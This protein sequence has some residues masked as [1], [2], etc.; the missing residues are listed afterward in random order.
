MEKQTFER[1]I[2]KWPEWHN[3]IEQSRKLL[4]YDPAW[5]R[6]T[7][8]A[9]IEEHLKA[10][11]DKGEAELKRLEL[12]PSLQIYWEDC[13]YIDYKRPDGS[14]DYDRITRYF[15]NR[16][17]LPEMPCNYGIVWHE[18]E[19]I[20][21]PWL[22]VE[23]KLH[24]RFATKELLDYAT[25]YAYESVESYL[26]SENIQPHSICEWLKGGRPPSDD[27]RALEC[28]HLKDD[29]GWT[30]CEIGSH[31]DDLTPFY[32]PLW[33]RVFSVFSMNSLGLRSSSELCG[34]TS[35]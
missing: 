11:R 30:Y 31:Y 19:D 20:H 25:R 14:T 27:S 22:R 16:K 29:L 32:R 6:D 17:S 26:W 4:G 13:F 24:A 7:C 2:H 23:I 33:M 28:V 21:D 10:I 9:W 18:N 1:A 15:S 34:L 5:P 35:L 3:S 8:I 12:P